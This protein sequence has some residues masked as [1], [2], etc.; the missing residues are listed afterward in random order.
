M[1]VHLRQTNNA[2]ELYAALQALKIFPNQRIALCTD[3]AYVILGAHGAA[4]RWKSRHWQG[5]SG[6]VACIELW[7][8]LLQEISQPNREILW[9]HVPSHVDIPG[10]EEA[11]RLSNVGRVSHPKYPTHTT[12]AL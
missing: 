3:S 8:E 2:P 1:L 12:P 11:D 4:H 7:E 5:S 6:C 10:N 9:V